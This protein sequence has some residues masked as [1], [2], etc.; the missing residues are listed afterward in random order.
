MQSQAQ[1][2]S[3]SFDQFLAEKRESDCIKQARVR[4]GAMAAGHLIVPPVVSTIYAVKTNN[5]MPTIAATGAAVICIGLD[6]GM[7]VP[8]F[9]WSV[10]PAISAIMISTKSN[11]ARKRLGIVMPEQADKLLYEKGIY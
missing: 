2:Q 11:D 8:I 10:P 7:G 3:Q 4:Q 5:W 9:S 6:A 1:N